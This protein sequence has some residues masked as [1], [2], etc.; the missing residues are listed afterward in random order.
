MLVVIAAIVLHFQFLLMAF[1]AKSQVVTFSLIEQFIVKVMEFK[2]QV[3]YQLTAATTVIAF[4][5]IGVIV[6][7][8]FTC[9]VEMGFAFDFHCYLE[10]Q[11]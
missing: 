1:V 7:D 6:V 9:L 2:L 3:A 10:D 5:C 8:T 4:D 11:G